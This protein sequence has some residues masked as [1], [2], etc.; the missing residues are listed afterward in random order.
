M[1]ETT[2]R[3]LDLPLA[4]VE[5]KVRDLIAGGG[6]LSAEI[7][8]NWSAA[9]IW[10]GAGPGIHAEGLV[11]IDK[12]GFPEPMRL[13]PKV[14]AFIRRFLTAAADRLAFFEDALAR[15]GDPALA[16]ARAAFVVIDDHVFPILKDGEVD[17][18]RVADVLADAW[19]WRLVGLLTSVD[20]GAADGNGFSMSELVARSRHVVVGAWD[21]EGLLVVDRKPV[22]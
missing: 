19:S 5:Q 7:L 17:D 18:A 12:G 21:G 9:A 22:G 14:I 16:R 13:N 15:P 2:Y 20:R 6:P 8:R 11:D 1:N 10:T 4:T 3:R